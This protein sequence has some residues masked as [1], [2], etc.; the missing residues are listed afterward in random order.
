VLARHWLMWFGA[1]LP[2]TLPTLCVDLSR[3]PWKC[4][5]LAHDAGSIGE[6]RRPPCIDLRPLREIAMRGAAP[7]CCFQMLLVSLGSAGQREPVHF[8]E[9]RLYSERA[10]KAEERVEPQQQV[11]AEDTWVG[12][13]QARAAQRAGVERNA[14]Y[15]VRRTA[16]SA[17]LSR[18]PTP[19][20]WSSTSTAGHTARQQGGNGISRHDRL[21][22]QA[23]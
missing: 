10:L 9:P 12:S 20:S 2:A 15:L 23:R 1:K 7:T 3:T 5:S 6:P 11:S 4:P 8:L 18:W 14:L 19:P 21:P 22:V 13:E 17:W 16:T